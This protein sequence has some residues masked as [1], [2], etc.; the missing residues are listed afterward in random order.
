M[1]TRPPECFIGINVPDARD[2]R[3]IEQSSLDLGMPR[4][5]C[6]DEGGII[7]V[8]VEWVAC[9]VGHWGRNLTAV[10]VVDEVIYLEAAK[11]P[12]VDKAQFGSAIV[13]CQSYAKVCLVSSIAG[14][15]QELA[16]H[17]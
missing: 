9:D 8:G 11:C 3:L 16:A 15:D 5:H 12:L 13:K 14:L 6:G 17:P 1:G 7:K 2:E 4:T 10:T